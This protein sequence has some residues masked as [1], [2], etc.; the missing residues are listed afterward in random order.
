MISQCDFALNDPAD[1]GL[2]VAE[3]EKRNRPYVCAVGAGC[4]KRYRQMNGLKY[5]YLNSGEH[6]RYGLRMLQ[7]GTHPTPTTP[8][9]SAASTPASAQIKRPMPVV[10]G[11]GM[12]SMTPTRPSAA[13]PYAIPNRATPTP[14]NAPKMGVWPARP[15]QAPAAPGAAQN[16]QGPMRP[17]GSAFPTQ[18]N[19]VPPP[20][21]NKP[22]QPPAPIAKGRD[23]VLFAIPSGLD[24]MSL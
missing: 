6:G 10:N 21:A 18:P 13:A 12:S 4:T 11:A 17:H 1:L 16:G 20:A 23:A 15:A 22:A 7:N 24:P 8:A 3:A 2:S 19:A 9:S 5:H 14:V